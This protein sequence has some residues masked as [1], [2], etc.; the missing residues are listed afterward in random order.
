[1]TTFSEILEAADGLSVDEQ[2]TLLVILSRRIGEHNRAQ[3]VRD[4]AAARVEF[5]AGQRKMIESSPSHIEK[6]ERLHGTE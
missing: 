5:A 1:M 3:L 6:A 2:Q 4:V